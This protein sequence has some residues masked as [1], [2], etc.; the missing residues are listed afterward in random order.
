MVRKIPEPIAP[1]AAAAAAAAAGRGGRR[2]NPPPS[3]ARQPQPGGAHSAWADLDQK[4]SLRASFE[5]IGYSAA[6]QGSEQ[7][8]QEGAS[9]HTRVILTITEKGVVYVVDAEVICSD[10][11]GVRV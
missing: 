6:M 9:V 10:H 5:Q 8:Q 3:T 4:L 7:G 2:A 1:A 11:V